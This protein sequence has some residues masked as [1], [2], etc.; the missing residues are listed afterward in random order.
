MKHAGIFFVSFVFLVSFISCK[1]T[2]Y[3]DGS[4]YGE[5]GGECGV[6][7][8]CACATI[9]EALDSVPMNSTTE[10]KIEVLPG[11]YSGEGNVNISLDGR[12]ITIQS[13][14]G[15]V[16]TKIACNPG[17]NSFIINWKTQQISSII[18]GF[19]LENCQLTI[20]NS[21]LSK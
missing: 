5:C 8:D 1:V 4:S 18:I 19:T 17:E 7:L 3:V 16:F 20:D 14:L 15:S 11:D 2:L 13:S 9:Q 10:Y 6:S 21:K 12:P